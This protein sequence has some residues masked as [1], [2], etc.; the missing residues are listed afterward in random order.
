MG[1]FYPQNQ[2]NQ[3]VQSK[4]ITPIT[5]TQ[6]LGRP[7]TG[8][9]PVDTT[10]GAV[11]LTLPNSNLCGGLSFDFFLL[12][13]ANPLTIQPAAGD[14]INNS[15]FNISIPAAPGTLCITSAYNGWFS[16]G[17]GT[18][19]NVSTTTTAGPTT[20]TTVA[21]TTTTTV[22][23]TTTTTVLPTTTTTTSGA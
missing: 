2:R 6:V 11:F 21:P 13:G 20:T 15:A 18:W 4:Q 17:D 23:P 7:D 10:A 16:C 14:T 1:K 22:A 5:A 8:I 9:V 3:G 12:A 19:T